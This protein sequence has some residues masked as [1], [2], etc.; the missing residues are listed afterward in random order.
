MPGSALFMSK[1][2]CVFAAS[3]M[4]LSSLYR[5]EAYKLGQLLAKDGWRLVFGG[6]DHGL[7]G[8][9]AKG[10]HSEGGHV[11][12]VIPERLDQPHIAYTEADEWVVT[13]D[14][15]DRKTLMDECSNAFIVLPGGFGT[16]EEMM[17][18]IAMQQLDFHQK[19]IAILNT[20]GF[21]DP[22]LTFFDQMVKE[23]FVKEEHLDLFHVV[24][25]PEDAIIAINE[26]NDPDGIRTE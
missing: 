9:T 5:D 23:A 2:V 22:L 1:S 10:V 18:T 20:N 3:S 15:R 16:L 7:M 8:A 14:L 4:R 21:Y 6:G 24:D 25:S 11:L 19:P 12:G 13:N 26:Y 17:E